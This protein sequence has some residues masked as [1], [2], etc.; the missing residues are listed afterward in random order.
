L[1]EHLM[2]Q[3][4]PGV[5]CAGEMLDWETADRRVFADRVFRQA[6]GGGSRCTGV[7]GANR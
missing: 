2:L 1:D 5:F 3:A 7:V 6:A 4:M